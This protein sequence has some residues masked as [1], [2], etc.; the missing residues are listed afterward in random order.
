MSQPVVLLPGLLCDG[1]L[2]GHAM[3]TLGDVAHFHVAD[4]TED[5]SISGMARRVLAWAPPR[6]SMLGLS[7]GGYVAQEIMRQAPG[8][9]T[10]LALLDTTFKPDTEEGRARRL[11]LI[12][13]A[14]TGNFKGVTP[15]LLPMLVH[16][17]HVDDPLIAG[18]VLAM[19]E[20]VGKEAFVRQQTAIMGRVDGR[21][22]LERITCPTLILCGRQDQLTPLEVHRDMAGLVSGGKLVIVEDCGH[23]SP[24]E[25]PRAV[26]AVLRYWLAEE[27]T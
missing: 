26:S 6:F 17:D 23:L 27:R 3:E 15:R 9:V 20:R 19:A 1:A 5:D 10:R 18:T 12:E 21:A 16:P 13:L 22:D 24:L 25:Q 7:M 14:Q 4:L 8:R 11:G 2:F